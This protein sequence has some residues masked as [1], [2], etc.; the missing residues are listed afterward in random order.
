MNSKP[1]CH[2]SDE[3][4]DNIHVFIRNTQIIAA[5][6]GFLGGIILIMF[7]SKSVGFGFIAG[8]FISIVNFKLLSMDALQMS[9]MATS[10][11]G[12]FIIGR[13]FVRYGMILVSLV[14]IAKYS[15]FNLVAACLGIF[16]VQGILI[17]ERFTNKIRL[18]WSNSNK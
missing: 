16:V 9:G 11:A 1:V 8:A 14:L 15:T 13:Y 7:W 6:S 3:N 10:K 4:T 5:I 2:E 12:T 17:I 18:L